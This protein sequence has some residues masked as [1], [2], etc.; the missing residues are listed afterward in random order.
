[1]LE[2]L[3]L[4]PS[5]FPLPS[6]SRTTSTVP[7]EERRDRERAGKRGGTGRGQDPPALPQHPPPA[8]PRR[9]AAAQDTFGRIPQHNICYIHTHGCFPLPGKRR[10]RKREELQRAPG[11]F[12]VSRAGRCPREPLPGAAGEHHLR[13]SPA[14]ACCPCSAGKSL[15]ET[16]LAVCTW[17]SWGKKG[18]FNL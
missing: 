12:H 3:F 14:P 9:G 16:F 17:L 4:S 5:P 6:S 11:I 7:G 10:R 8:K 2:R 15:R 18:V 1:M 13:G